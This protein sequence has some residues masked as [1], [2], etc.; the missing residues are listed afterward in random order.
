MGMNYG[1]ARQTQPDTRQ[2]IQGPDEDYRPPVRQPRNIIKRPLRQ[3]PMTR[4]KK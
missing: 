1:R 2:N 4:I 3:P